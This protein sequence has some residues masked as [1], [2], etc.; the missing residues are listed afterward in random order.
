MQPAKKRHSLK[1]A[2]GW[3][4]TLL[5]RRLITLCLQNCGMDKA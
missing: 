3:S 2:S 1:I 5:S 4:V